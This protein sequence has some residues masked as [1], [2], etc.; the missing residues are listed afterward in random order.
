MN[1]IIPLSMSPNTITL[2]MV[3]TFKCNSS[4]VFEFVEPQP[5]Y[6]INSDVYAF[7]ENF[8]Y[9]G[10]LNNGE[11]GYEIYNDDTS[12]ITEIIDMPNFYIVYEISAATG[13]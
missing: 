1:N 6:F 7:D 12:K 11:G 9:L 10:V 5:A 2:P 8:N 13:G 4:T 3:L